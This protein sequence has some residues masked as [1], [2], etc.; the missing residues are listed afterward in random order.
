VAGKGNIL[1]GKQAMRQ[2]SKDVN[3]ARGIGLQ[4]DPA[5]TFTP[6]MSP[7]LAPNHCEGERTG[8]T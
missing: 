7:S 5:K 1:E 4:V 3:S 8:G 2:V 6:C